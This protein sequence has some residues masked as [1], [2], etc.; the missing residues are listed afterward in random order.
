MS[1][2]RI[3]CDCSKEMPLSEYSI[4][5]YRCDECK[6]KK[7]RAY[8]KRYNKRHR[9]KYLEGKREYKKRLKDR[10][11]AGD[12]SAKKVVENHKKCKKA[13]MK[14]EKGKECQRNKDKRKRERRGDE[15]REKARKKYRERMKDASY[16]NEYRL[17]QREYRMKAVGV[18]EDE[19][20]FFQMVHG[21]SELIKIGEQN[22]NT[23][24]Q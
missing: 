11:K 12:P 20:Q 9:E 2:N 17:K 5:D 21:A 16:A 4:K 1:E 8:R 7:R 10:I 6:R 19:I 18:F 15:L 13:W 14:T 24:N 23:N 22:E 3:C